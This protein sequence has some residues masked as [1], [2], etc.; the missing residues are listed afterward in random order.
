MVSGPYLAATLGD[1]HA[2]AETGP[3]LQCGD[4]GTVVTALRPIG[5]A[6]FDETVYDVVAD[7]VFI[8]KG[9]T[10]TVS[11]ITGGRI[12]VVKEVP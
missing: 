11:D 3:S 8:D 1:A 12:L 5:K 2:A 9:E 6:Q 7:G 10:V 4:R